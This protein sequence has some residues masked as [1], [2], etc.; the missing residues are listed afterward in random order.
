M[1]SLFDGH[2][3]LVT[4]PYHG[5][6]YHRI[7]ERIEDIDAYMKVFLGD[8]PALFDSSKGFFGLI[9]VCNPEIRCRR[10]SRYC[11]ECRDI[12]QSCEA[13]PERECD[14]DHLNVARR[15]FFSA[16]HFAYLMCLGIQDWR[17]ITHIVYH[18]HGNDEWDVL[19]DDFRFILYRHDP[20]P[21]AGLGIM[22]KSG[23]ISC[24]FDG[25]GTFAVRVVVHCILF[26]P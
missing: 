23:R 19:L 3:R 11:I 18:P 17:E 16:I 8:H 12:C 22:E 15:E 13:G 1:Q 7:P 21:K 20:R 10:Q 9:G 26:F 5:Q 25:R 2:P 14:V 24:K 6:I 4:L